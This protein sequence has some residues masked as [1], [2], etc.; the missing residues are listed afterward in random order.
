MCHSR[1]V[2]SVSKNTSTCIQKPVN[3]SLELTLRNFLKWDSVSRKWN[4]MESFVCAIKLLMID[5]VCVIGSSTTIILHVLPL[6]TEF[7]LIQGVLFLC[8]SRSRSL[9][10]DPLY[11]GRRTGRHL[12]SYR[13]PHEEHLR[14]EAA[15]GT[16]KRRRG[17]PSAHYWSV[18][19]SAQPIRCGRVARC[20]YVQYV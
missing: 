8:F 16:S 5:E 14:L 1:K 17:A 10:L 7:V 15:T 18:G 6:N 20:A 4:E 13:V 2:L 11:R 3:Q 12:G 19:H 9:S